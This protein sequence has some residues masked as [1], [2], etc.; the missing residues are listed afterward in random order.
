[1]RGPRAVVVAVACG[2]V[3]MVGGCSSDNQSSAQSGQSVRQQGGWS[4]SAD[5]LQLWDGVEHVAG[6]ACRRTASTALFTGE[7]E[8]PSTNHSTGDEAL[9]VPLPRTESGFVEVVE[10]EQDAPL[11]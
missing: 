7:A 6:T 5:A 1:M 10:V 4:A 9:H 11:W 8:L 3:L 2:V